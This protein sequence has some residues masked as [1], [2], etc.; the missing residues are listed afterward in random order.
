MSLLQTIADTL[1]PTTCACCGEVLVGQERQLCLGCLSRLELADFTAQDDNQTA[2]M[3]MGRVDCHAATSLYVFKQGSTVRRVVHAMKFHSN[4][5]LC[6]LMGRQMGYELMR[7]SRFDDV[8]VLLPVPLHWLRRLNR[9][10]N[11]SELLCRGIAQVFDRPVSVGDVVRHRYTRKQSLQP[12]AGRNANVDGAFR[13]KH[14]ERLAG[15]HV[16]VVDDV[17]TT[18]ATISACASVL[19]EVPGVTVSVATLCIVQR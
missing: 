2:R 13:L 18:G 19:A 10:Y 1:F 11:Q 9:G 17:L 8:D 7:N 14:P 12:N 4:S 15:K 16:L 3:L 6:L 5:D